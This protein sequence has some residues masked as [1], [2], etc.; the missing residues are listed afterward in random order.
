MLMLNKISGI[1]KKNCSTKWYRIMLR[2]LTVILVPQ[3]NLHLVLNHT[4]NTSKRTFS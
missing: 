4:P 2:Y 1:L 3:T